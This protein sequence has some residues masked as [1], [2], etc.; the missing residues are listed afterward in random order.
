M[1]SHPVDLSVYECD[2]ETL[3]VAAPDLVVLPGS[4][5]EVAAVV[6]L[7]QAHKIPIVARGAGTGLSGGATCAR[8]G[9]SLVLTRMNKIL[10]VSPEESCALVEVGA[11][12]VSVSQ[13]ASRYNLYFAPDPS[14]QS[15]STIGGNI[16]ENAGGPHTLKYGMTTH[17]ILGLKVVLADGE[18][19]TVGG[20]SRTSNDLDLAGLLVGSGG[21]PGGGD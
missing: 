12:N 6:K 14:S 21:H 15:A 13:A 9:I 3:D 2:A 7:G 4:T 5:A 20:V 17:H 19:L 8:G 1:L 16:A 11:T 18:I 10:Y